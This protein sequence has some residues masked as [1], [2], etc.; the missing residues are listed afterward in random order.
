MLPK[1]SGGVPRCCLSKALYTFCVLVGFL[2]PILVIYN[3]AHRDGRCCYCRWFC[4]DARKIEIECCQTCLFACWDRRWG[5][6]RPK[7]WC[8][9][10][11]QAEWKASSWYD[12]IPIAALVMWSHA[13]GRFT[14]DEFAETP[15]ASQVLWWSTTTLPEQ[16]AIQAEWEPNPCHVNHSRLFRI[17]VWV[18]QCSDMLWQHCSL[19]WFPNSCISV[20]LTSW[21]FAAKWRPSISG[22][23]SE[24]PL[25]TPLNIAQQTRNKTW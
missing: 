11:V 5:G 14:W 16:S 12:S 4:G 10:V 21:R 2:L 24:V 9:L 13:N 22:P 25:P 20:L 1:Y 8:C 23:P 17:R 15:N 7:I 3:L 6:V 19:F 18:L